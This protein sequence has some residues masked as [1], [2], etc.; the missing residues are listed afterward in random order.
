MAPAETGETGFWTKLRGR[1]DDAM[2]NLIGSKRQRRL[3]IVAVLR[4]RELAHFPYDEATGKTHCAM[5]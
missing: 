3:R 5:M 1:R 4:E 2:W